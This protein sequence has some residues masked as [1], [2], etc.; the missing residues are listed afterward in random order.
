MTIGC[1]LQI[2]CSFWWFGTRFCKNKEVEFCGSMLLIQLFAAFV[3]SRMLAFVGM[4]LC[5]FTCF[6]VWFCLWPLLGIRLMAVS[7]GLLFLTCLEIWQPCCS[8]V[9]LFLFFFLFWRISYPHCSFVFRFLFIYFLEKKN[10]KISETIKLTNTMNLCTAF[11]LISGW[12][13]PQRSKG[14]APKRSY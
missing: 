10:T 13:I 5:P 1:V 12:D 8:P 11:P 14:R 2:Y 4:S 9:S 7:S 6:R 3:W